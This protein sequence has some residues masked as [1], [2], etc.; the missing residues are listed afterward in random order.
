[1][2]SGV[3]QHP[4][5]NHIG[6][7]I[8]SSSTP[9]TRTFSWE[10]IWDGVYAVFDFEG[11]AAD[12]STD[13]APRPADDTKAHLYNID[14]AQEHEYGHEFIDGLPVMVMESKCNLQEAIMS[15]WQVG[16]PLYVQR[17]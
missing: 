3:L 14:V 1:M 9:L 7:F 10:V 16:G 8:K 4:I 6:R 2:H 11:Q 5:A 12:P 13:K 17:E 15:T